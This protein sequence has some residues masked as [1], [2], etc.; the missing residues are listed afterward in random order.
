MPRSQPLQ[1]TVADISNDA[2]HKEAAAR[3]PSQL[4]KLER[5]TAVAEK[6][7]AK[8]VLSSSKL[9]SE[10]IATHSAVSD[11]RRITLLSKRWKRV[12][13][14]FLKAVLSKRW[15]RNVLGA[16]YLGKRLRRKTQLSIFRKD[17][18]S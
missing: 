5:A 11:S 1:A 4:E 18:S 9:T 10:I 12:H 8:P 16:V 17:L 15:K 13:V 2:I 6:K 7:K 3:D 14:T